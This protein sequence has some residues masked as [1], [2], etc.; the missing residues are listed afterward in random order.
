MSL[1]NLFWGPSRFRLL[2]FILLMP[3]ISN[4]Q[5]DNLD[6]DYEPVILT[7]NNLS[8]FLSVATS[9]LFV[10][11]YNATFETWAQIPFQF[12]DVGSDGSY[13]SETDGTLDSNDELAFMAK[14]MGD[15]APDYSWIDDSDSHNYNRFEL[16]VTD[17]TDSD[18]KAWVYVYRSATLSY[19]AT[20]DYVSVNTG[21]DVITTDNYSVGHN[22]SIGFLDDVSI[23]SAG[24]GSGVDVI[25]RQKVRIQGNILGLDYTI[26][27]ENLVKKN[28]QF[29]DGPIRVLREITI[30]L[31]G[32]GELTQTSISERYYD[33]MSLTGGGSGTL[34]SD[35]GVSYIRQ[36][37][38]M[39]SSAI[40]MSFYNENNSGVAIDGS[41]DN[42]NMLIPESGTT[43]AMFT[44]DQ[45]TILQI[46]DLPNLGQ[47]QALYYWDRSIG[48]TTDNTLDTGDGASYGDTGIRFFSPRNGTFAIGNTTFYLPANQP[49]SAGSEMANYFD[50]PLEVS[51]ETQNAPT[52]VGGELTSDETWTVSGSPY[53][54]NTNL[55]VQ[56]GVTLTIEPGVEIRFEETFLQVDGELDTRGTADSKITFRAGTVTNQWG[57]I[58]FTNTSVDYNE[59]TADGSVISHA[60]IRDATHYNGSAIKADNASPLVENND[61]TNFDN[62]GIY[63]TCQQGIIRNNVIHDGGIW[64]LYVSGNALV[65]N[66]EVYNIGYSQNT[67]VTVQNGA[68]FTNN[69]IHDNVGLWSFSA[70]S[71]TTVENNNFH[72]TGRTCMKIGAVDNIIIRYN[73]FYGYST[74]V[75]IQGTIN[76]TVSQ[77]NFLGTPSNHVALGGDYDINVSNNWWGTTDANK[78]STMLHDYY[79]DF[80]LGI[81]TFSPIL[82][83]E[84]TGSISGPSDGTITVE[85][86]S[87]TISSPTITLNLSATD[88]TEMMISENST[89]AGASWI[90]F[91][92]TYAYVTENP[93]DWIYIKYRSNG[94]L[95][96]ALLK[97]KE[98]KN[99]FQVASQTLAL[100]EDVYAVSFD[101]VALYSPE[102]NQALDGIS[103]LARAKVADNAGISSVKTYYRVQGT[104]EFTELP[105]ALVGS[106]YRAQIPAGSVTGACVDYYVKGLDSGGGTVATS[107]WEN[108]ESSPYEVTV[109]TTIE[110][111]ISASKSTTI[112]YADGTEITFSAGSISGDKTLEY[113]N[114]SSPPDPPENSTSI[115]IVRD[116]SFS[117]GSSSLDNSAI[118]IFRYTDSQI[119]GLNES[120]LAAYQWDGSQWEYLGGTVNSDENSLMVSVNHFS[121]IGVFA[122]SKVLAKVKIFLEGPYLSGG[123]MTTG[124]KSS[125]YIPL[126]SPYS[127]ASR[128]VS[129]IPA[130]VVDWIFVQ[131]RSSADGATVS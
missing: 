102:I 81:V 32:A 75:E 51:I 105:M 88:A 33:R 99:N 52:D 76:G 104:T 79:D 13:F 92:S 6:R 119:A 94:A 103:I 39:N 26:N 124:L 62:Y 101:R 87:G 60:I 34:S 9:D 54:V 64:A 118:I 90:P 24:G 1:L 109:V 100:I 116:F 49:G 59:S 42:V 21:D 111:S 73:T 41:M 65:D 126:S 95:M 129:S 98:D 5:T 91:Q 80:R 108:A 58:R 45:G 117:D 70:G 97:E 4:A 40:G 120:D 2:I 55:L 44:G 7:G 71:N 28:L 25:D 18:K 77:N 61:I 112:E 23:K 48:G 83:G 37:N 35:W 30:E 127:S 3:L 107:P 86:Y 36:S 66:N 29:K 12:D 89:F 67:V 50:N 110:S 122:S 56:S 131:L 114:V 84:Y 74:T 20:P 113:E 43:W 11:K 22:T 19:S 69:H 93:T 125:N 121:H 8:D 27:E 17:G 53:I 15:K 82:S 96:T 78:I 130:D 72:D 38:D 47:P 63:M 31:S 115:G 68:T 10:Y 16:A 57:G 128:T 106:E 14:D 123:T 46:V 85:N